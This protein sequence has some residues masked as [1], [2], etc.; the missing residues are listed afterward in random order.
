MYELP[1]PVVDRIH[2]YLLRRD[3]LSGGDLRV[4]VM[5]SVLKDGKYSIS[6]FEFKKDSSDLIYTT[7]ISDTNRYVRIQ[8]IELPLITPEDLKFAGRLI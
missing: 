5:L 1:Q 3:E 4:S 8:D 6:I 7:L 2:N